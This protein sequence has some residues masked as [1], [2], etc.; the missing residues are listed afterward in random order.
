LIEQMG[1]GV[2]AIICYLIIFFYSMGFLGHHFIFVTPS[3]FF[4]SLFQNDFTQIYAIQHVLKQL[5]N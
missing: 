4:F 1:D 2:E 3:A 5:R